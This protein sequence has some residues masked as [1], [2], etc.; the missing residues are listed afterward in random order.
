[1]EDRLRGQDGMEQFYTDVVGNRKSDPE[2]TRVPQSGNDIYLTIDKDLQNAV[3]Q[4]L[5]QQ[6]AGIL[7]ANMSESK[8][9][10]MPKA[11]DASQIRISSD[12]VYFALIKNHVIDTG[13]LQEADATDLEKAVYERFTNK[14]EQVFREFS[15]SFD[16]SDSGYD[17]LSGEVKGYYDYLLD[18]VKKKKNTFG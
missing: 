12:E 2:I 18:V 6:I 5:E 4:M 7:L 13:R 3:Y 10:D 9:A 17:S 14:K 11:A 15:D 16:V 1:M 8:R